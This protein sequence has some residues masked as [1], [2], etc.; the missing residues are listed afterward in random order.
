MKNG[1][2]KRGSKYSYAIRI[3]DPKTGKTKVKKVGGFLTEQEAK[4]AR[5]KAQIAISGG[6]IFRAFKDYS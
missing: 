6:D 4:V 3:P 5:A 1:V 2:E